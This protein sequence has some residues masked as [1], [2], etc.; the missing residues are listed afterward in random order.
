MP[1]TSK[2]AIQAPPTDSLDYG[3]KRSQWRH[4]L[5]LDLSRTEVQ[6]YLMDSL[7]RVLSGD[8]IAYVKWDWNRRIRAPGQHGPIAAV[9]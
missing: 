4:Q 6:E 8:N 7:S 9:R 5:C 2:R 3:R 1:K